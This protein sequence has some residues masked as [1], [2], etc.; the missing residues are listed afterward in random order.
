M[1]A[2]GRF[3]AAV[4]GALLVA[5]SLSV[6]GPPVS[7]EATTEVSESCTNTATVTVL[8]LL[9]PTC[10]TKTIV[11]DRPCYISGAIDVS[12]SLKLGPTAGRLD[13]LSS[14]GPSLLLQCSSAGSTCNGSTKPG[15]LLKPAGGYVGMCA[16]DPA[17]TILGV[18]VAIAC[19]VT[20]TPCTG[21]PECPWQAGD[22]TTH[23]STAWGEPPTGAGQLLQAEYDTVYAST[24]EVLN[25]GILGSGGFSMSFLSAVAVF[26]YVPSI[27]TPGALIAD[28]VDPVGTNSSGVFGGEVVA[29][30]LNIDFADAGKLPAMSGL[31][32]GDLRLCGFSD[33]PAL[34]GMTVRQFLGLANTGLGGGSVPFALADLHRTTQRINTAFAGGVAPWALDHLVNGPCPT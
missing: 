3:G 15:E 11:C 33:L 2:N 24:N 19:T 1:R 22:L 26:A 9:G 5:G 14:A 16:W 23:S 32:L 8:S 31:R 10:S 21:R 18:Q 6:L 12:T 13:L 20:A 27:G 17:K 34:N 28:L 29:L 25:V 7:A 30:K 4:L